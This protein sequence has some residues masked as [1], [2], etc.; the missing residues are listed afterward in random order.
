MGYR[1]VV[2][3][4]NDHLD[5]IK[6]DPDFAQ[7]LY[8]AILKQNCYRKPAEINT[9]SDRIRTCVGDVVHCSH[10]SKM[11]SLRII[12]FEAHEILE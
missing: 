4:N 12:N 2:I 10:V 5:Q 11:V 3:F 7:K 8:D 6:N 9:K 1:T